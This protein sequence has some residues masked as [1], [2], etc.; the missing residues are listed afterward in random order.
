[1]SML[2]GR[3]FE[4]ANRRAFLLEQE[5]KRDARTDAL[6]GLR[7]RRALDEFATAAF[8]GAA[9]SGASCAVIIC[10]IDH[11]KAINDRHGHD[12]G[13]VVIRYVGGLLAKAVRE[14]DALGRW[15]G[16]EFLAVLP[17]TATDSSMILAERMR[18]S[19]EAASAELPQNLHVTVS[20]GVAGGRAKEGD[21]GNWDHVLKAADDAL[22][23]AKE[24]GRNRVARAT[25]AA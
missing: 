19:V 3:V 23:R 5:L 4:A 21:A 17:D 25:V 2:L 11:F 24:E 10:D 6:T 20:L 13:D 14:S 18:V 9:R 12:V 8:K 16:E 22:Y 7:N 15:G 1:M